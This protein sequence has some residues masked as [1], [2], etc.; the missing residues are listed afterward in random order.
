MK[1]YPDNN[2]SIA[3]PIRTEVRFFI[4]IKLF[5]SYYLTA[6]SR[7]IRISFKKVFKED[8]I[9]RYLKRVFLFFQSW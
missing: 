8:I 1:T 6:L 5:L 4:T 9:R 2:K 3:R 7:P